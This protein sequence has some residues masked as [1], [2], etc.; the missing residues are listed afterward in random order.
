LSQRLLRQAIEATLQHEGV[1]PRAVEVSIALVDDAAI[2][3]LNKQYRGIDQPTD[4]LSFT[5]EG[6]MAIPGAP[7]LLGDIVISV[8]TAARQAHAGDRSLDEEAAQLA[9]HGLLHLLGYDDVTPEGYE[10][11]VRTGTDIWQRVQ[12]AQTSAH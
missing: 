6:E 9:I 8:D 7:K 4:V 12:T 3:A 11:M 5:Q 2:Q 10:K 1:K